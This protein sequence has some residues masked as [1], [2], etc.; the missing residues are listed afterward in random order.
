MEGELTGKA[1]L[2]TGAG[3]GI[4][5]AIALKLAD[6]GARVAVND[7]PGNAAV[8]DLVT[9]IRQSGGEAETCLFNVTDS[10]GV[11]NGIQSVI[12][13]WSQID[14]LVNNAGIFR[15]ALILRLSEAD[16]DAV[17]DVNLKGAFLCS[18]QVLPGMMASRW[19]RII[20]I[21]SV[22]GVMGNLGRVNYSASKGGLAAFTRSLAAEVGARNVTVNAIAP[23]FIQTQMTDELPV[24]Y[25]EAILSRTTLKRL[26]TASEVADLAGFLASGRASY[27]T[28]QVICI[29]GGL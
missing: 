14:I 23:G 11:K 18:K 26:G 8:D 25:R 3:G 15:D 17:M 24:E 22:A 21:S 12:G 29:D 7:L 5:R 20:N 27:I 1:A 4:G 16:W 28:G 19:G 2:V 10:A 13:K 9:K 6:M